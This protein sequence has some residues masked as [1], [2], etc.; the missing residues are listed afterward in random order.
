MINQ[1]FALMELLFVCFY[2]GLFIGWPVLA[3]ATLFS[4]RN[5]P[6]PPLPQVLWALVIVVV[7]L[8]GALAYWIVR[9]GR[10]LLP[11]PGIPP[12]PGI[13]PTKSEEPPV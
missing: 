1:N 7:P 6:L 3:I 5:A 8:L 11:Q 4:L 10:D 12:E 9:P 2:G 13:V